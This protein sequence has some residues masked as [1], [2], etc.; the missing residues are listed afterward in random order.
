M[1][2]ISLGIIMH[3]ITGR[4]G[5]NQH[6]V[7]SILA[8]REQGGLELSNGDRLMP[9]P[10][11]VGRNAD[12]IEAIARKHGL[13]RTTTDLDSALADPNNRIF[14]DAGSTQMRVSLLKKAIE[15]GKHV[16][17]EKPIS[18]TLEEALS[19]ATLAEQRGVKNGVVQD[20][21]YLPGLR[22][23]AL[24][25][26]SGFFGKILSVRGEF[27]YWVFEGDWGVKAQRPSWNYR[28]ADG[29]GMILDML[30]HWRYVLDNLFGEVKAVSCYASTHIPSRVDENG[31][32]Y[33]ADADDAAYS[34]FELEGG[35]VA[36]INSSWAVRVRRDDL[37]TFQ[38][39]GTH[40]SAVCGLTKCWTQHRV[41]TPKP[42]WNPDQPQTIDFYRTW[43]EVPE[44]QVFD[45]GFKA[46]WED[47][48][49]YV[50]E[51]APW[52]FTLREGAKGV[53]LAELAHQSWK[54]RRW[55]D[56][57]SLADTSVRKVA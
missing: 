19:V 44:T 4:M 24:L 38:V 32:A 21:L 33:R 10:I 29:G 43:D 15:A 5:Y 13:T 6:L 40:G 12:K 16:Y 35:I 51:D 47:Y 25:K 53:Q 41:N 7:R 20:K 52:R 3:G 37:V 23:I 18:E 45:N 11:L 34:T 36:H 54:E 30:P 57:P 27:G 1:A 26:D 9:D 28:A 42:V 2:T 17:C 56:V 14:F 49:R 22:K 31:K 8:I 50:V 46:Q 48:L 55:V 39:D